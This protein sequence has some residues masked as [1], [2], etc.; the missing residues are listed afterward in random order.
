MNGVHVAIELNLDSV[1]D[2][3]IEFS[4]AFNEDPRGAKFLFKNES[5]QKIQSKIEGTSFW[6]AA[7][8]CC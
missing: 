8:T 1:L 4:N 5:E 7:I 6:V 3:Y 2:I